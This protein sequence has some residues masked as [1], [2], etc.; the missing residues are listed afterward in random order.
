VLEPSSKRFIPR[1]RNT[2]RQPCGIAALR[3]TVLPRSNR[4]HD[5]TL[6]RRIALFAVPLLC[7][8]VLA[9]VPALA[10][11]TGSGRTASET[12]ALAEFQAVSLNGSIDIVVRQGAQQQVQVQA[13]DNLLPLLETTVE[14]GKQGPTLQVR[15][16]KGE[17][18]YHRSKVLVTVV[19]PKLSSL[20]SAGSSDMRVESFTTPALQVSLSGSGDA[21]L[22]GLST[23]DLA[24]RISGSGDVSG[25]GSATKL[26]VSIAGSG[27]VKL[28]GMRADDV[29]VSIAGSGDALVNAQ[30]TLNVRI[31]G[32]GDV[33][34]VGNAT[35]KSSVAG[36]GSVGRK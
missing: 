13:D 23:E 3:G 7:S 17:S 35:L 6:T 2:S 24:V 4:K 5:M 10:A 21:K 31:A 27:N 22:E 8:L 29:Q 32:S 36:S 33:N 20:A 18:I 9:P 26:N 14:S 30:K 25:K 34:Y 12:R 19:L 11:T 1:N 15:W 16:K 28:D